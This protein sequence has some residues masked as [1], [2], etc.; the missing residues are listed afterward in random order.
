MSQASVLAKVISLPSGVTMASLLT[1]P[2][3][4]LAVTV[5]TAFW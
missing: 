3:P 1:L 4:R 5:L 2:D